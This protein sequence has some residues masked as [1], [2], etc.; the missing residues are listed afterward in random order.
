MTINNTIYATATKHY[1]CHTRFPPTLPHLSLPFNVTSKVQGERRM[2]KSK[3]CAQCK[4]KKRAPEFSVFKRN[5]DGLSSYC[6]E[7][8]RANSKKHHKEN[9]ESRNARIRAMRRANLEKYNRNQREYIARLKA[10]PKNKNKCHTCIVG[11][12]VACTGRR[13]KDACTC[14]C[15]K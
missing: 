7:C 1:R 14:T 3:V 11:H 10:M 4:E 2:V 6:K 5:R 9:K 12:H 15:R 8:M 13:K